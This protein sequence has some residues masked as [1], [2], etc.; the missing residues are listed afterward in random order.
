MNLLLARQND[1]VIEAAKKMLELDQDQIGAH[2][3]LGYAYAAKGQYAEAIAAYQKA[4]K[5]G[6]ES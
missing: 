5:L 6:Y 3:L 4:I 1:Q 2:N